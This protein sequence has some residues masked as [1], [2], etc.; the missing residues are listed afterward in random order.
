MILCSQTDFGGHG[1]A[2]LLN[3]VKPKML[4]KG[5]SEE[6]VETMMVK[7]PVEWLQF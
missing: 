7:N 5:F 6:D 2:H 4:L 1:F 3:N